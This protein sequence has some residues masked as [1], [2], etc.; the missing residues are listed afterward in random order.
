MVLNLVAT[1]ACI[2]TGWVGGQI[3]PAAFS[4]MAAALLAHAAFTGAPVASLA[5]A[6]AAA[7]TTAVLRRPLAS[8][9]IL[10][11]FF[12]PDVLPGLLVGVGVA[13]LAAAALGSRLPPRAALVH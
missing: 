6:G 13:S 1:L 9:L 2:G 11:L 12:P 3:F 8:A 7:G 10:L 5:A 4:G